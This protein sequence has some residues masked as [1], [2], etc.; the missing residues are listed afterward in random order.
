V[1]K[2][3]IVVAAGVLAS[4]GA[5]VQAAP[6]RDAVVR[7]GVGIGKVRLG[8]T[9]AQVR[10]AMGGPEARRTEQRGFGNRRVELTW[11]SGR[12]DSF[13]VQLEGRRGRERVIAVSTTRKSERTAQG[14]GPGVTVARFRRAFP[15]ARCRMLLPRD[16]GLLIAT[17]FVVDAGGGRETAFLRGKWSVSADGRPPPELDSRNIVEV[18]VRTRLARPEANVQSC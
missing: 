9:G 16:G 18:I 11:W 5:V 8:M 10:R 2:A 14:L 6:E 4:S 15:N 12:A 17:E 13:T 7:L 3:A 1:L